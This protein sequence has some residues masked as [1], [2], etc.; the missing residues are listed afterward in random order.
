MMSFHD[1][2]FSDWM[3][4]IAVC[5]AFATLLVTWRTLTR[6]ALSYESSS[7]ALLNKN[8]NRGDIQL[9]LSANGVPV[10][11]PYIA[12]VSIR[13]YGNV[14]IEPQDFFEPMAISFS[15]MVSII[16]V[17][18]RAGQPGLAV[19]FSTEGDKLTFTP[20]LMNPG[21]FLLVRTI[22]SNRPKI[23]LSGRISGV[24]DFSRQHPY[25][26]I[27][28]FAL[29]GFFA[30]TLIS[31][32]LFIAERLGFPGSENLAGPVFGIGAS[33]LLIA[34]QSRLIALFPVRQRKLNNQQET[35]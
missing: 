1:L 23:G 3:G 10:D 5:L 24:T 22:V 32:G 20:F 28:S 12:E 16:S 27:V 6:K 31:I 26:R 30:C 33:L 13:N 2:S 21:D 15:N 8:I 7:S 29:Y 25:S 17:D 4:L 14:A 35:T 18:I 11:D 34:F 9:S 19:D